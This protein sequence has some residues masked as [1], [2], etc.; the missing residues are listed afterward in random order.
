MTLVIV[1]ARKSEKRRSTVPVPVYVQCVSYKEI[2]RTA[3]SVVAKGL[4]PTLQ[5]V[6][7]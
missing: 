2:S 6:S 7:A 5:S 1:V 4:R 3:T